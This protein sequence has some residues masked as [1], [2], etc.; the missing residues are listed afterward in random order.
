[1]TNLTLFRCFFASGLAACFVVLAP[2]RADD[3]VTPPKIDL[4]RWNDQPVY[5]DGAV[6]KKEQGNTVLAIA[7]EPS[8][9]VTTVTVDTSSGFEDLD[10]TAV[11]AVKNLRFDGASNGHKN[12]PSVLKLTV[13]F[14]LTALPEKPITE[15]DIYALK[16][17]GDL[18]F[19]KKQAPPVGSLLAPKPI[20]HTKREWDAL[21]KQRRDS[22]MPSTRPGMTYEH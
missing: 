3:V 12:I 1:M 13:H 10:K 16:D 19:C 8:G 17:V 5:P 20:C 14:Q 9:R 21:N 6:D 7:L 11:A 18:I 2:V 22:D 15:A 4:T